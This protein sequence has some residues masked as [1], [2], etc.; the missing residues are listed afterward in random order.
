[1][2]ELIKPFTLAISKTE[3]DRLH[4]K[5]QDT[6]HPSQDVVANAGKD[7]GF[8]TQ[9][10]ETLY[11]RWASTN[12]FSWQKAEENINSIPQYTT[13][14]EGLSIHFAHQRS[15]NPDAIPIL[16][17]HG[18]P[19]T[20]YEFS[21]IIPLLSNPDEPEHQAF[22]CIAP[23]LPG[24]CFSDAPIHRGWTMKD[25]ARVFNTLMLRLGYNQYCVQAGDW[26]QFVARELGANAAY[27]GACKVVHLNYCPGALPSELSDSELTKREIACRA[28]GVDWRTSHV[29]YAVLM[30]TRPHTVGWMLQDNPV[31]LLAFVGEK[32]EEAANPDV[33]KHHKWMDHI[34][35]TNIRHDE[36]A[37]YAMQE[38]NLIKCPFG[39]TSCWFDTAPNSKRAVER[40]GNL[41]FYKERDD[42]G[43]F[44][45]LEDP[46]GIAEDVRGVVSAHWSR[47]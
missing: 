42:T 4:K 44:A 43:H 20:F 10:A 33:Q 7:Y 41:V 38:D 29:G 47:S 45:C 23:S 1:M 19:G 37:E 30:R 2:S 12:D 13:P 6:R 11:T 22:H 25:T 26:G 46:K 18:W 14:I 5:L 28:K 17:V 24:F 39:Y 8:E 21:E 9:W 3:V 36:F 15:Q 27:A 40:T 34:L 32:Y 16:L 35:T 31:G